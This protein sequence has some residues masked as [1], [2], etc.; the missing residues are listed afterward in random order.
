MRRTRALIAAAWILVGALVLRLIL[1]FGFPNYDTL[2]SLAWGQQLAR[3][4][5]PTYD[6]T[7]APT[8]HPLAEVAGLVLAPLGAAATLSIVLAI[9]YVAL[10]AL[11][12]LVY[13]LGSAWFSWPVGIAAAAIVITR[14]EVLSYGVRAYVDIPYTCLI[15]AALLVETRRRR[16]GWPVIALLDIAGLLRPE[17]WLF[18]G[19]YWLYL[20]PKR[21]WRE[22]AELAALVAL[23]PVIWVVSDLAITGNL[24]WSLHHTQNTASTLKR[25]TGIVKFPYTGA[26]RLGEVLGPDGLVAAAIGG[27]LSLWLL[28]SRIWL[29]F[30]AGIVALVA[31]AIVASSGLPIDDR[32]TFVLVALL[33]ICGGASLFGWRSL[34]R[35]HPRR[36]LWQ[37]GSI[38]CVI[39]FAAF[40]PWNATRLHQTFDSRNPK[41]Q[42]LSAQLRVENDLIALT[43]SHAVTLRCGD[44]G[45]PYHT[46]IPL[47]AL[48][49]HTSPANIVTREI[50]HGTF[51]AAASSAVREIYLLDLNDPAKNYA[52]PPG[53]TRTAANRSWLV[54]EHCGQ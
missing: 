8:P 32:Y 50:A 20:L 44:V 3:G 46:P 48:E 54:Y 27:V 36:R 40:I 25:P 12:Y 47:L 26:R 37:A 17:A 22:R 5:T 2:Y 41:K 19:V 9:A 51:I 7:L 53:F 11:P 39:A 4:Q 6:V 16:A 38:V 45:V 52:V 24:L 18:A 28:R 31:F 49:L 14:Y 35:D 29:A 1:P 15:L 43:K 30:C 42:S 23:A 10:A 21:D 34:P 13:R 33:A